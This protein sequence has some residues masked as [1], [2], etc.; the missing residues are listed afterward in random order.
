VSQR[1]EV[2]L[3]GVAHELA[4]GGVDQRARGPAREQFGLGQEAVQVEG[5][6]RLVEHLLELQ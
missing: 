5:A 2:V 4:V 6:A 1:V 3:Q